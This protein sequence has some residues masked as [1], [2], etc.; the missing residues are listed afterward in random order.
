MFFLFLFLSLFQ[1][2][3]EGY[4]AMKGSGA[5]IFN[6]ENFAPQEANFLSLDAKEISA[7]A[8]LI[9]ELRGKNLF[10]KNA[11]QERPIASL[12]KLMSSY[13]AY[14]IYQPED[15]FVFDKEAI[16]QEGEVGN[17]VVGEKI[18]R[19]QALKASLVA[20]SN[21]AIYLLA[22]NY[23][24]ENFIKLM[25]EKAKEIGMRKTRFVDPTGISKDNLSTAYDLYLLAEKIYTT[26]PEIFSFS[27]LEKVIINGKILWTTNLLLPKYKNILVGGKT[28]FTSDAGECLLMIL[29]FENS[30]F[31]SVVILNSKD[32]FT[33]AEKIIKALKV[34]YGD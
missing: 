15:V 13:L 26:V 19:D 8:L 21:D 24:L 25:N 11:Y 22:K 12:T 33:D 32:R 7:E 4:F 30:P 31:V 18:T 34:Y 1:I 10:S 6:L 3:N 23:S 29:K 16:L 27:T 17:F 14:L 5:T 2:K 28:G 9:K 20:S